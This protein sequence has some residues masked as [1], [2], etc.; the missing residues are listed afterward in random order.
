MRLA[1]TDEVK[2]RVIAADMGEKLYLQ[3]GFKK[4]TEVRVDGDD[5]MPHGIVNAVMR[6]EPE[7]EKLVENKRDQ[8]PLA[9]GKTDN[10]KP[11]L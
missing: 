4:L 6:Y 1:E 7:S 8:A 9:S 2:Q 5:E 3:L 10:R 11:S